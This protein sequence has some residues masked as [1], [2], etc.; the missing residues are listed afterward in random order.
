M[1]TTTPKKQYALVSNPGKVNEYVIR[2]YYGPTGA[3]D[4]KRRLEEDCADEQY[5][6]M[7]L[8]DEKLT[9]EF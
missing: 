2:W 1:K 9:T 8:I 6:V 5:D 3:Y 4:H 7:K